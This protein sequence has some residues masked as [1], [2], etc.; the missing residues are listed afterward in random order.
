MLIFAANSA[1][2]YE[3]KKISSDARIVAALEVLNQ[4]QSFDTLNSLYH[5]K[6]NKVVKVVFYELSMLSYEYKDHYAAASTDNFGDNYILINSKYKNSPPEALAALIAH[7]ATHK[8]EKATFQEEL[9]ATTNEAIQWGKCLQLNP[10]LK[11]L[12]ETQYL[13]IKRLNGLS[14][15][16]IDAG[17]TNSLI[18]QKIEANPFYQKQLAY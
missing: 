7:E 14:K 10:S 16:Y 6:D 2:A 5:G 17:N 3:F 9:L 12:D 11:N 1:Q 18:A 15:A 13:L 8:L 4:T